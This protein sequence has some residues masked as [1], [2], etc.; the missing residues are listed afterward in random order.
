[1]SDERKIVIKCTECHVIIGFG[2][3]HCPHCGNDEDY[4]IEEIVK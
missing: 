1:M 3:D 2:L 4:M